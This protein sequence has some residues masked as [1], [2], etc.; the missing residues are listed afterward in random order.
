[1]LI[2]K[3]ITKKLAFLNIKK[4]DTELFNNRFSQLSHDI[5]N[6][7]IA[8]RASA[9]NIKHS[10]VPSE[11]NLKVANIEKALAGI[12]KKINHS[13]LLLNMA[14]TFSLDPAC[15]PNDITTLS[16]LSCIKKSIQSYPF[17]SEKH[18]SLIIIPLLD[19]DFY[20]EGNE[21]LINCIFYCLI[22][23]TLHS[24]F[25]LGT[26]SAIIQL[27]KNKNAVHFQFTENFINEKTSKN[28]LFTLGSH[29]KSENGLKFIM[30]A[31]NIM[32]SRIIFKREQ[33]NLITLTFYLQPAEKD[34]MNQSCYS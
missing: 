25:N 18:A 21:Y 8:I 16:I 2:I 32:K 20:F 7:L 13:M 9:G 14:T 22:K 24:I 28:D 26:G 23:N 31:L 4:V 11:D 33:N 3:K 10:L 19:D 29:E 30:N 12:D 27:D 1:M 15:L 6:N 5:K 34:K 17:L